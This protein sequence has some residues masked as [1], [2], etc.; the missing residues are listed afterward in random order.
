MKLAVGNATA[1]LKASDDDFFI[2]F[3]NLMTFS[4][5]YTL[6]EWTMRFSLSKTDLG[7]YELTSLDDVINTLDSVPTTLWPQAADLSNSFNAKNHTIEYAALGLTY[8]SENWLIQSEMG[9]SESGW[10]I[11]SSNLNAYISAGYRLDTAILFA[12]IS[13]SENRHDVTEI[14]APQFSPG[15]VPQLSV[16]IKQLAIA[17]KPFVERLVVHQH[18]INIGTKWQMSDNMVLKAQIDHF[19]IQPAGSG[20]WGLSSPADIAKGHKVNVFTLSASMVF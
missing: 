8:D 18:S 12:G 10:L 20:L 3:D 19:D 6:E 1:K 13:V 5:T 2:D 11:A 17:A 16:P 9:V 14:T 15:T 4:A 7:D